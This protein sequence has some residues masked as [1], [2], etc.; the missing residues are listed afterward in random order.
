MIRIN[1]YLNLLIFFHLN[2]KI[3]YLNYIIKKSL[4]LI[5][6]LSLIH[7]TFIVLNSACL[8]ILSVFFIGSVP[9][10]ILFYYKNALNPY[11]LIEYL[12]PTLLFIF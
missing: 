4:S 12:Y 5:Y 11:S 8:V 6:H 2:K 3:I 7:Y 1:N 10:I 9:Y